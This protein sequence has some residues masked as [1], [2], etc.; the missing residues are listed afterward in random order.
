MDALDDETFDAMVCHMQAQ[1][2]AIN[3]ANRSRR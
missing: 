3:Q 1:A 2:E